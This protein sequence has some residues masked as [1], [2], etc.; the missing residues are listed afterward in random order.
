MKRF[1]KQYIPYYKNYKLYFLIAVI[2]MMMVSIGTAGTAYVIKPVLD[3]IFVNKDTAMLQM[4]PIVVLFLYG[5]KGFGKF[6]QT[7]YISY[8]GMDIIKQIRDKFLAHLLTQDLKFFNS[9]HGGELLSRI[10]ND[11]NMIQGAVTTSISTIILEFFT[12]VGLVGVVIY[13]SPKLAFY[14]LVVIPLVIYPLSK[15]AKRMKK[16]AHQTQQK[17]S[18][19]M[20][21]L[22]EIFNNIELIIA[23]NSQKFQMTEFESHNQK[24]FDCNHERSTN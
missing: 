1:F 17:A 14:G 12:I 22:G 5:L 11:I 15:L 9:K 10:N 8:I 3:E 4:L 21:I 2:G 19:L 18:I 16:L 6:L 7:Y 24:M 20:T 13:Q 23:N